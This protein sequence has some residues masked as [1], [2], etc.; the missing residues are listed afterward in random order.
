[1]DNS[2]LKWLQKWQAS[3]CDGDWEHECGVRINTIDNPGWDINIDIEKVEL[4]KE[5]KVRLFKNS[6]DDW[7]LYKI[8]NS[9]FYAAGDP[10]KLEFLIQMF[11]NF[12][13]NGEHALPSI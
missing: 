6:E 5:I 11:K 2:L 8:E 1:M 4:K 13:E 3:Q 7:F 10:A 12:I 9:Y